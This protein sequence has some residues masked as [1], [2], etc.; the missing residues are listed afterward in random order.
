MHVKQIFSYYKFPKS[1]LEVEVFKI[2]SLLQTANTKVPR[3]CGGLAAEL[4]SAFFVIEINSQK[5][6]LGDVGL[7]ISER[8]QKVNET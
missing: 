1:T 8:P 2:T 4:F 3:I 5:S 7:K 6:Y